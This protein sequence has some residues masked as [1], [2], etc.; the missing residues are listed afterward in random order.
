[1]NGPGKLG[2]EI[3]EALADQLDGSLHVR[4]DLTPSFEVLFRMRKPASTEAADA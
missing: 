4:T 3:V 2:L 1:M